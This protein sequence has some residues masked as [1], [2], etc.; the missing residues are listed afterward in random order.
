MQARLPAGPVLR[1]VWENVSEPRD[2]LPNPETVQG[3]SLGSR[4]SPC[5][6][7]SVFKRDRG[8]PCLVWRRVGLH[9]HAG[10]QE[11]DKAGAGAAAANV[12]TFSRQ[13][14]GEVEGARDGRG[15][16]SLPLL[17]RGAEAVRGES[18]AD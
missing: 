1:V 10:I 5:L 3:L 12:P 14:P 2:T 13:E 4:A 17:R 8:A 6:V 9:R 16:V 11:H 18:S 15:A 7:G